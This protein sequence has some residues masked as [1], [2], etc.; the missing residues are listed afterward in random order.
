MNQPPVA[1]VAV[2]KHT[3]YSA[4]TSWLNCGHSYDLNRNL[5]IDG[6]QAWW[7]LGGNAVH[8]ATEHWD[9]LEYMG[10][11]DGFDTKAVF[12]KCLEDALK[13][14]KNAEGFEIRS[15]AGQDKDWWLVD[16][17]RQV[18]GY[19]DWRRSS[20]WNLLDIE[21]VPC[22]EVKIEHEF[23]GIPVLGYIDR[24]MVNQDGI[25]AIVDL[26]S[27]ARKPSSHLQLGMYAAAVREIYG[28]DI[29]WGAY[30]MTR[31]SEMTDL[32][33]LVQYDKAYLDALIAPFARARELKVFVANPTSQL[34][35]YCDVRHACIFQS[36]DS[37][38][39]YLPNAVST[40]EE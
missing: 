36:G 7:S 38:L 19:I 8:S 28:I 24:I 30:F 33:S 9:A 20:G 35:G 14:R 21:G 13:Q 29:Q 10:D 26:K 23:G 39:K 15:K 4:I 6:V 18:Q 2:P 17:P 40:T 25:G 11:A 16:G 31:K 27:G 1:E 34:C 3:S 32:H 22:I 5:H 12:A 37:A